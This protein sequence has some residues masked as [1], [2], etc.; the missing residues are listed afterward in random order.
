MAF[1]Q[2]VIFRFSKIKIFLLLCVCVAFMVSGGYILFSNPA[3]IESG[4]RGYSPVTAYIL[5]SIALII[6]AVMAAICV[7]KLFTKNLGL[8]LS[9]DGFVHNTKGYSLGFIPWSHVTEVTEN[10]AIEYSPEGEKVIVIKLHNPEIYF[11]QRNIFMKHFLENT[12]KK[13][14]TPLS[15]SAISLNS[16]HD[17]LLGIFQDY[18]QDYQENII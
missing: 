16:Q 7:R 12:M 5:A 17:K 11:G 1:P 13:Y 14:G 3:E 18:F 8:I 9:K 10:G 2:E 6:P 4:M 15:V